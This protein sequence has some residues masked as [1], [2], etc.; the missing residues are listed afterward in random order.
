MKSSGYK[1]EIV[2]EVVIS[3]V[4]GWKRKID[5]RKKEGT[6]FYR[7]A[8]KTLKMRIKKKLTEKETWF[9]E[10]T[11]DENEEEPGEGSKVPEGG[12][13]PQYWWEEEKKRKKEEKVRARDTQQQNINNNVLAVMFI[14]F[15]KNSGLARRYRQS[16][17]NMGA[18]C[19]YRLKFVERAGKKIS[20]ILTTSNPWR[21]Q[22]C[23]R[24]RCVPCDTKER[25]GKDKG[26]DCSKRSLVYETWCLE[27][28]LKEKKKIEKRDDLT[29]IEKKE[30][31][32]RIRLYKYVGETSRSL[33]ERGWEHVHA[34]DQLHSNSHMLKHAVEE[35]PGEDVL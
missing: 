9:K 24:D 34:K 14:P 1:R 21:G 10:K 2:R 4:K 25:T 18:L 6:D 29:E 32:K 7:T 27:C 20:D 17:G 33:Y 15:T 8:K 16:E 28:E 22:D 11:K 30:M 13:A 19:D 23:E 31:M 26:Q 3:G 12:E 5:R 35:H